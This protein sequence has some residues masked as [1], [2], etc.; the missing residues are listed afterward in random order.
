MEKGFLELGVV[1]LLAVQ[2]LQ[3][4]HTLIKNA[5]DLAKSKT[6][7]PDDDRGGP[8]N[9][10]SS[11]P[12]MQRLVDSEVRQTAILEELSRAVTRIEDKVDRAWNN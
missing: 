10:V 6:K 1:G 9:V 7:K 4:V 8:F 2:T 3:I 5:F 12:L 11:Y